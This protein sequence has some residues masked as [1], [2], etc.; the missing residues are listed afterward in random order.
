VILLLNMH[1]EKEKTSQPD[2]NLASEERPIPS[3]AEGDRETVEQDLEQ[4][5]KKSRDEKPDASKA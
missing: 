2:K 3:Q 1:D 4:N 5:S